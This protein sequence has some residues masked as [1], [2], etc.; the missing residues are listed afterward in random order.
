M[1]DPSIPFSKNVPTIQAQKMKGPASLMSHFITI[2]LSSNLLR[3]NFDKSNCVVGRKCL[4]YRRIRVIC[5]V[6]QSDGRI[7]EKKSRS[8]FN[9]NNIIIK[10][11]AHSR[12]KKPREKK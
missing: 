2:E 7:G 12:E 9:S 4:S 3:R 11:S 1:L 6:N 10:F 8:F 5:H